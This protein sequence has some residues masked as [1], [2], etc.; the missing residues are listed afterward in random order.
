MDHFDCLHCLNSLGVRKAL[1]DGQKFDILVQWFD[2]FA[3][4]APAFLFAIILL[5]GLREDPA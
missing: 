3:N 5:V 2:F 1:S 4:A